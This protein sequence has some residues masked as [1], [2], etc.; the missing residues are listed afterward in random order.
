MCIQ[1]PKIVKRKMKR[2]VENLFGVEIHFPLHGCRDWVD[3]KA[4]GCQINTIF[5]VGANVG[6][7]AIKFRDAFPD[8]KIYCF[9]PASSNFDKLKSN[10]SRYRNINCHQVALGSR[11]GFSTIY[12]ASS[13]YMHSLIPPLDTRSSE[14]IL[15]QTIDH[16]ASENNIERIDL[17]KID[18]EGFDLE[19]IKGADHMLST[20]CIPFVLAEVGFHP[21]NGEHVLFDDVRALL[22][23][24]G[25]SVFGIYDQQLE[26]TGEK[27][28][29]FANVCFC[30]EAAFHN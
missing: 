27:R 20:G 19:V 9:E 8:G 13:P 12:L 15:V 7:S 6:Q 11:P 1:I 4:S 22:M 2:F 26:W 5:D 28:L 30:N 14:N 23:K 3:I 24:K 29:R 16:F 10:L 25:F 21:E 17:L 18:T